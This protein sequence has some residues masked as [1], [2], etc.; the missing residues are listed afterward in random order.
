MT[1]SMS[2]REQRM[3]NINY[4]DVVIIGIKILIITDC[5]NV[6]ILNAVRFN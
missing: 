4:F 1:Y 6:S 2:L 3:K 5:K